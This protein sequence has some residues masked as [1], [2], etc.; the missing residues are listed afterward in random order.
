MKRRLFFSIVLCIVSLNLQAQEKVET[1]L[2]SCKSSTVPVSKYFREIQLAAEEINNDVCLAIL[3][4]RQKTFAEILPVEKM[5]SFGFLVKTGVEQKMKTTRIDKL[6]KQLDDFANTL[7]TMG[8]NPLLPTFN[9]EKSVQG[10]RDRKYLYY[11]THNRELQGIL[12]ASDEQACQ[13]EQAFS[14]PCSEVLKDLENAINPYQKNANALS[15]FETKN[16]LAGISRDWNAYFDQSRSQTFADITLT[17]WFE[18]KHFKKGYLVGPPDRQ[19]FLLHPN[20]VLEYVADAPDGE[21]VNIAVT[22]EWLGV[23]WWRNSVI[24]IPFG[25]SLTSLY[26][27]RPEVQD[28]GHGLTF[29]F[30]NKYSIGVVD[31]YGDV[32]VFMSMDLLKLFADKG[33]QASRYRNRL[34]DMLE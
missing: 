18:Q 12:Q 23:N 16:R 24:G 22:V 31:H 7:N 25:V 27:D 2:F 34:K 11:F 14:A 10:P 15:A 30:D 29:F 4:P 8:T 5:S 6:D 1:S 21:N 13:N 3:V 33:K 28:V 19:W 17:S 9:V 26:S 32:G 20:L